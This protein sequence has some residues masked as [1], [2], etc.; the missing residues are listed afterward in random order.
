[1]PE[2]PAGI[3]VATPHEQ[4]TGEA[5]ADGRQRRQRRR[6]SGFRQQVWRP[7]VNPYR[8]IEV[9]T[10]EQLA[11][12]EDASFRILENIGL[13]FLHD[14][15][16]DRL[17]KV[18]AKVDR[19]TK[20]VRMD[21]AMVLEYV[22]K[23]PAKFM[24]H[25][26]NPERS[27]T[28]GG[29][30]VVFASVSSAPNVSDLDRGRRPGTRVDFQNLLRI[31][32]SLNVVHSISGY[33]VEPADLPPPVRHLDA[34][35]DFITLTDKIWMPSGIGAGRVADALALDCIARGIS[36][37]EAARRP[38][39]HTVINTNSPLRVDQ[40]MIDG[41]TFLAEHGQAVI[42]TPFTLSGAMAPA[43]LAGALALQNAEAL[44][45]IA[46]M[47]MVKPGALAIYGCFTS[48]VDM[49][50]GAPAFGTPEYTRAAMAGGQLA[51][52]YKLPY[53][54]SN[55]CSANAVD[56]QAA[57][58]SCMSLWGAVM[59]GANMVK[60]GAGW[61][62]GGLVASYEK[63]ILDAEILQTMSEALQPF[64]VDEDAL[65]LDAIKE[66][67]PGGHFFGAAHTLQRYE[68]AFYAPILS[69][70]RNF[71]TWREAGGLDA[72]QRANAIWKQ[73][74]AEYEPPPIDPG[75]DEALRDYVARRKEEGGVGS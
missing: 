17:E 25:A 16:L 19:A 3:D 58:E 9:L 28:I 4:T 70:W 5:R 34:Q 52:R 62:E 18:G 6:A 33:P 39:L 37:D 45:V 22:A 63:M 59:G 35:Y 54:S 53:R 8:P 14:G 41:L 50:S 31:A 65:G 48:N 72:A 44:G 47:Q 24:L 11:K 32:Q 38:G 67:G 64:A 71:E 29:N 40:Q 26:R 57:Y 66:V 27:V 61:M 23:A 36:E 21:R 55:C 20:R 7:L 43:T 51:R 10:E 74:L 1:M 12:V 42:V 69:D 30:H 15:A 73:I 46:Y 68:T 60:H 75:V 49:K 2:T 13:E 56:A